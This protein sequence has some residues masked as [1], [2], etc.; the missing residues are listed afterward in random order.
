MTLRE[1]TGGDSKNCADTCDAFDYSKCV[2]IESFFTQRVEL[3]V[4]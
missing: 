1:N 4:L 3:P 2:T